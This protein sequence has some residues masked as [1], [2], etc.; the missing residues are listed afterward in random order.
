MYVWREASASLSH[1]DIKPLEHNFMAPGEIGEQST[2]LILVVLDE[3]HL[4]A[5]PLLLLLLSWGLGR[6][7]RT[8]ELQNLPYIL[9]ASF[10][11]VMMHL[12][13][14]RKTQINILL[15]AFT[16]APCLCWCLK[17]CQVKLK[18][19][20]NSAKS[21]DILLSH[22]RQ[23]EV[24]NRSIRKITPPPI[25]KWSYPNDVLL[26]VSHHRGELHQH[27]VGVI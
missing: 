2:D 7:D 22:F 11:N 4:L 24:G 25:F 14:V 12:I 21:M 17:L 8:R 16:A 15:T 23:C 6:R 9:T 20:V 1:Q 18:H 19:S 27:S 10:V 5:L 13:S 26:G 3:S